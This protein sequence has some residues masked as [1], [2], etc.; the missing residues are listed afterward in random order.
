M[1]CQILDWLR[2]MTTSSNKKRHSKAESS[3]DPIHRGKSQ[4]LRCTDCVK[5]TKILDEASDDEA[6]D[7][8]GAKAFA[9]LG[10]EFDNNEQ[11]IVHVSVR[12]A[13]TALC[14]LDEYFPED[15]DREVTPEQYREILFGVMHAA[16]NAGLRADV[17]NKIGFRPPV[18]L[19][20]FSPMAKTHASN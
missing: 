19:P 11:R 2:C 1:M 7:A 15:D 4:P 18:L 3:L 10:R 14:S 20:I 6:F 8:A 13:L 5:D 16:I 9:D 17:D 12:A